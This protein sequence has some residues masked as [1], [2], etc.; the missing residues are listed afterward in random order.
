MVY[1]PCVYQTLI[2]KVTCST[3]PKT[4]FPKPW[5]IMENSKMRSKYYLSM[6]HLDQKQTVFYISKKRHTKEN[7]ILHQ[8]FGTKKDRICAQ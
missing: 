6:N 3:A 5:N 1:K 4:I 8:F 7:I 2:L